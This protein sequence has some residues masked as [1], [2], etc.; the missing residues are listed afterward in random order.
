VTVTYCV[1]RATSS[2]AQHTVCLSVPQCSCGGPLEGHPV[3][4]K[5]S[6]HMSAHTSTSLKRPQPDPP[7]N[8]LSLK[9]PQTWMRLLLPD[10]VTALA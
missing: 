6:L 7:G 9:L 4:A 3:V 2:T 8:L 5:V 10:A 1:S